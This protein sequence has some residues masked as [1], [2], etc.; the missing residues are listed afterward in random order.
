MAGSPFRWGY[1]QCVLPPFLFWVF[2]S[3]ILHSVSPFPKFN[4]GDLGREKK[5][6]IGKRKGSSRTCLLNTE[7]EALSLHI[8]K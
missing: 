2:L 8:L 3:L 4:F 1:L 5:K 6:I 7:K